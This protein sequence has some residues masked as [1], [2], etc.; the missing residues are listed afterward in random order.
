MQRVFFL[1]GSFPHYRLRTDCHPKK[2]FSPAPLKRPQAKALTQS[3]AITMR[4]ILPSRV[5]KSSRCTNA[6]Q[7]HPAALDF[8]ENS[9]PGLGETVQIWASLVK[10]QRK[11]L[12]K[13]RPMIRRLWIGTQ[14]GV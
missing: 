11:P 9:E 3:L 8:S 10:P 5:C 2:I 12:N 1:F 7:F 6:W 14:F 13:D 4:S